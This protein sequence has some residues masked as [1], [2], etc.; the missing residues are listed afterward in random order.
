MSAE[1]DRG[2][3]T[4]E[5]V[6]LELSD[7]QSH[8]FYE[9]TTEG[10]EVVIRFG[11]IGTAGQTARATYDTPE[12]A[13]TAATKKLSEKRKKGYAPADP[14]IASSGASPAFELPPILQELSPEFEPLRPF[15]ESQLLPFMKIASTAVGSLDEDSTGD[16][17]K[18]WQSKIG[19]NP[20]L[21]KGYDHPRDRTT[22]NIMPLLAQIDCSEVP[23]I[24]GFDFPQQGLLQFYLG[25]DAAMSELSPDRCQVVYFPEVSKVKRDLVT[26]FSFIDNQDTL[27]DHAD[28][29]SLKFSVGQ[30]LFLDPRPDE[31]HPPEP[32]AD[33]YEDFLQAVSEESYG[34]KLGGYPD[35]SDF[36][37]GVAIADVPGRLLLELGTD[38]TPNGEF[39]FFFIEDEQLQR[40]DFSQVEVRVMFT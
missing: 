25:Y 3:P 36:D 37:V 20:Y 27:R 33:L 12:Q 18:L 7:G 26:D 14:A 13:Q 9:V 39:F 31:P 4:S 22:G 24:A 19:G 38:I 16:P 23:A 21:P 34:D 35:T 1:Q 28:I 8:K 10:V 29:Y 30:A 6:Y 5:T 40:R 15:L 11:R 17:L 2:H 32:L